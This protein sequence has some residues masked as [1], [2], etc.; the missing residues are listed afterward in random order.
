MMLHLLFDDWVERVFQVG[1]LSVFADNLLG[2]NI[3][4]GETIQPPCAETGSRSL[5]LPPLAARRI[6]SWILVNFDGS[7]G[8]P[9]A[10]DFH[11]LSIS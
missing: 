9:A 6:N 3:P 5:F 11:L 10:L 2:R 4:I 8:P 7:G 1:L